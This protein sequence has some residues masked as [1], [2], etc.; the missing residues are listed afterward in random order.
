MSPGCDI[1][2]RFLS[3]KLPEVRGSVMGWFGAVDECGLRERREPVMAC[4]GIEAME[5]RRRGQ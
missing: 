5:D 3:R 4:A 1:S 2:I